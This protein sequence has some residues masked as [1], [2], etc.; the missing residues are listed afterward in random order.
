MSIC[1]GFEISKKNASKFCRKTWNIDSHLRFSD[2]LVCYESNRFS[3]YYIHRFVFNF[4]YFSSLFPFPAGRQPSSTHK[5]MSSSQP[6][7]TNPSMYATKV[8]H[9]SNSDGYVALTDA[10][11]MP[12]GSALTFLEKFGRIIT[13]LHIHYDDFSRHN[14]EKLE[15]TIEKYCRHSLVEITLDSFGKDVFEKVDGPFE[16]VIKVF[17]E[18]GYGGGVVGKFN[19]LFPNATNLELKGLILESK[20]GLR[21]IQQHF[22][23]LTHLSV[24]ND[25]Y[26]HFKRGGIQP[27]TTNSLKRAILLNPQLTSLNL[28]SIC[29]FDI[30]VL[31]DII[32]IDTDLL[33]FVKKHLPQLE[34]LSLDLTEGENSIRDNSNEKINFENLK[35]FSL[36]FDACICFP[37]ITSEKL[38]H[39]KFE[40][41]STNHMTKDSQQKLLE[42]LCINKGITKLELKGDLTTWF[43]EKI[44]E[45]MAN[46]SEL[47]SSILRTFDGIV[48]VLENCINLTEL[49]VWNV[50]DSA[51]AEL[52]VKYGAGNA[53]STWTIKS[54]SHGW[55]WT[56][57]EKK[58]VH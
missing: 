1:S 56:V 25:D 10:E 48:W 46:V 38:E 17:I 18:S 23:S 24:L 52:R 33:Q 42:L 58:D 8:Y 39:L 5:K 50:N 30:L 15:H 49:R 26:I 19:Q 36:R 41:T 37:T 7:P 43:A 21:C 9:V 40:S 4:F 6:T 32:H 53:Q 45:D 34:T 54:E 35:K 12:Y 29:D 28:N 11:I 51:L 27:F 47:K 16:K 22:P 57:F 2:L 20:F 3:I 14:R 13:K 55:S 44:S 31:E